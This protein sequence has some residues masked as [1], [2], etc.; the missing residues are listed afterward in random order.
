MVFHEKQ[1]NP[2]TVISSVRKMMEELYNLHQSSH[3]QQSSSASNERSSRLTWERPSRDTINVNCDAAWC[4][5]TT[6]GGIGVI[7]RNYNGEV[8]GGYH[9]SEVADNVEYLEAHDKPYLSNRQVMAYRDYHSKWS[10]AGR[11]N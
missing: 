2:M 9:R 8:V 1:P 10:S 6:R 4:R 7:A 5:S 11:F 3:L